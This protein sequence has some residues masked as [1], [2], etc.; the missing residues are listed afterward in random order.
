MPTYNIPGVFTSVIDRTYVQPSV[1]EGRSVLIAGF[2]KY[3]EDK[4]Y[5]FSDAE[6]MKFT[7][8]DIDVKRYGLGL[9]YGLDSLTKTRNMIFK[10]LMPADAAYANLLFKTDG[11]TETWTELNNSP[12]TDSQ[13]VKDFIDADP[14]ISVLPLVPKELEVTSF[15]GQTSVFFEYEPANVKV[16]LDGI[17]LQSSEYVAINGQEIVFSTPLIA[18]KIINVYTIIDNIPASD[19]QIEWVEIEHIETSTT[20]TTITGINYDPSNIWMTLNG[21]ELFENDYIASSGTEIVFQLGGVV[22]NGLTQGDVVRIHSAIDTTG[23]G[24]DFFIKEIVIAEDNTVSIGQAQLGGQYNSAFTLLTVEGTILGINDYR[25]DD[26]NNIYFSTALN[27]GQTVR[28]HTVKPG[29]FSHYFGALIAKATGAGYNDLYVRFTPATDVDKF[30]SD[31]EGDPKYKF[32]FL[33]AAIYEQT[34]NSQRKV[35]DDFIVSLIDQDPD[36]NMPIVS[37]I[38]GESLYINDKFINSND[39]IEYYLNESFLP[40]FKKD[41]N[42]NALTVDGLG[43]PGANR[44]ILIDQGANNR[45]KNIELVVNAAGEIEKKSTI[46][47]GKPVIYTYYNDP[48]TGGRIVVSIRIIDGK[49]LI[50]EEGTTSAPIYPLYIDGITSYFTAYITVNTTVGDAT[51]TNPLF[52]PNSP[53]IFDKVPYR[54]I[55]QDLYNQL[56]GSSVQSSLW[57]MQSGYNGDNLIVDGRLNLGYLQGDHLFNQDAK[58]LLIQFYSQD[59]TIHEVLYPELDFDYVPDWTQDID[60]MNTIVGF[61]DEIGF[62]MPIISL[63]RTTASEKDYLSRIEDVYLSSY[64]TALYSGQNNDYHYI[65]ESGLRISCPTSYYAMLN[66]LGTD[67]QISI[68]EPMANIVKGQL[69]VAGAKLSYIAKSANIEKLRDVQINTIIKEIDGIY[70]IDQLTAYKSASKLSRINVVKVIHRMRKDLPKILKDLLQRKALEN[71]LLSAK[72]RTEQYM[73]RW[74]VTDS[75]TTDGIFSEVNVTPVFIQE[76]L[77]LIVSVAVRPIG[78][79]EKIE[80]PIT[81]Y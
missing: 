48:L 7:L 79:I 73:A 9:I 17:E 18:D 49:I 45:N 2:S 74:L 63:P 56:I 53:Y 24:N 32:N 44:L 3:G 70:F 55:R 6:T 58:Q 60:V 76:E 38:T 8:G 77:K 78:T 31:E 4:F 20:N 36:S 39:F 81:V 80:V 51:L 16:Y 27:Q 75:N 1:V 33:R 37:N 50:S 14:G 5:N 46:I 12:I 25:A 65:A 26:N 54:T 35:S 28:L 40:V 30:Y 42:I 66:H 62:T 15:D 69:P 11:T 64:N 34:S 67:E 29:D 59:E 52:D 21:L 41:L 68:T 10:R 47:T 57:Q 19:P 61:A 43:T 72:T 23:Y 71:V 13:V 22:G